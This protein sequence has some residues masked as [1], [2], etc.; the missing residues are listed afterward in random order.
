V[1]TPDGVYAAK[2]VVNTA[3]I[4]SGTVHN[5]ISDKKVCITPQRG[6]YYIL[7]NTQRDLVSRTIFQLPTHLGKG[8]LVVP[9]VDHNILL[10]PTSEEIDD[11][12]HTQ[13]TR[14]G[15]DETVAKARLTLGIAEIP[16][17]ERITAFAGVR[18]KHESKDFIIEE[19]R[20]GFVSAIG[21]DSPGLSAAPAIALR[22][23]DLVTARL[24]PATNPRFIK[25]RES[26]KSESPRC[27]HIVCRCET[28]TEAEIVEAIRRVPGARNL[29]ALKR[30]T[31]AQM[32]RCQG[33]FC[34]LKLTEI[35]S[36]ELGI[37][38]TAVTKNGNGS[39]LIS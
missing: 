16:V 10:G 25:K 1:E 9:T 36:R 19:T 11:P 31:R 7:D 20:P 28:V 29:D 3:G 27:G 6:Q 12:S 33:G 37:D 15:L 21:I 18:A 39:W 30:R 22:I 17:R 23:A 26:I 2:M 32:G 35:L 14:E 4:E 34:T 5:F 38:E 13:T 24:Q 8:V